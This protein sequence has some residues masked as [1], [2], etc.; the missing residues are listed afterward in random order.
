MV[1][2]ISQLRQCCYYM[3]VWRHTRNFTCR[4]FSVVL[5]NLYSRAFRRQFCPYI[6]NANAIWSNDKLFRQFIYIRKAVDQN[7]FD[8]N[9]VKLIAGLA[10]PKVLCNHQTALPLVNWSDLAKYSMTWSIAR[11]LCDSWAICVCF[12]SELC[13]IHAPLCQRRRRSCFTAVT[14]VGL[15]VG[16]DCLRHVHLATIE[17]HAT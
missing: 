4:A 7:D 9:N 5:K 17:R 3:Y 11:P 12:L 1:A 13:A 2:L 16:R 8:Q 10:S 14:S 6:C 15:R